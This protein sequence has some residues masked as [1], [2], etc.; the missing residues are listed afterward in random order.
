MRPLDRQTQ[1]RVKI[2]PADPVTFARL[3]RGRDFL[4][5]NFA[6]PVRLEHAANQACLSPFHF[7]RVFLR[8]F[9]ETPHE[10]VT[11]VRIGEAKKRLLADH[12]SVTDVCFEV[13]YQSLGSFTGRFRS[14]TGLAPGEFRRQA[15]LCFGGFNWPL[16][17]IPACFQSFEIPG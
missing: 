15:R 3:C 1:A 10:F 8:T 17:Y 9:G 4:A 16:Y 7:S 11:R 13:G 6:G 14:L 12:Q 2:S 5:A